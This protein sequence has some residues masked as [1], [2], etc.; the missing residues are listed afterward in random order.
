MKEKIITAAKEFA[1]ASFYDKCSKL[2]FVFL[3]LF[4]LDVSTAGGGRYLMIGPLSPRMIAAFFAVVFCIPKFLKEFRKFITNPILLMFAAFLVYLAICAVRGYYGGGRMNVLTSDLKG[5]MWLFLVPVMMA[6]VTDKER[7][8]KLLSTI[9]IGAVIQATTIFLLDILCTYVLESSKELEAWVQQIQLGT[10]DR[11]SDQFFRFFMN[12]CPY[13]VIACAIALIRQARAGKIMI[14]YLAVLA[15]NLCALL[16]SFTRSIYGCVFVAAAFAVT[17]LFVFYPSDKKKHFKLLAATLVST[18]CLMFVIEFAFC[19]NY[20]N[21]AISRTFGVSVESSAAMELRQSLDGWIA[22]LSAVPGNSDVLIS[23]EEILQGLEF[24]QEYMGMT[25]ES[26]EL[27]TKTQSELKGLIA[28]NPIFGN[29]LGAHAT[30]RVTGDV[31][32]RDGLD[33]YFYLDILARMGI[34]GL[35]LYVL[36]FASILWYCFKK[37]KLLANYPPALAMLSGMMGFWAVTWFNPWMN[38]ALG[39]TGYAICCAIPQTFVNER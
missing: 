28:A 26:D 10:I 25:Q 21:F 20:L 37:R 31:P 24:Q 13:M 19:A 33:E 11:I 38:A 12:S 30:V 18:C 3:C 6:A 16:M 8:E 9:V 22:S 29:G 32:E 7:L 2:A 15:V 39:I 1:Q 4:V 5:F 27:R 35:V 17:A 14:R 34:F 23:E 36:P